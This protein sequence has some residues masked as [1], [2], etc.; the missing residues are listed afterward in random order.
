MKNQTL[1]LCIF[2]G[3]ARSPAAF[4]QPSEAVEFR[5]HPFSLEVGS[6]LNGVL[7]FFHL[8]S[9][10]RPTVQE[11][12]ELFLDYS[13]WN[14]GQSPAWLQVVLVGGKYYLPTQT[15][16]HPFLTASTG[17]TAL[18]GGPVVGNAGFVSLTTPIAPVLQ[19]GAGLDLMMTDS[20][21]L[22]GAILLGTPF[23]VRPELNVR[24][25]F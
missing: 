20:L 25:K 3:L 7:P 9:G 19:A 4:A 14:L 11:P 22:S 8:K 15:A 13:F 16:L 5:K 17:L 18:I 10:W 1:A 6:G 24:W 21:G 2:M 23:V 12:V